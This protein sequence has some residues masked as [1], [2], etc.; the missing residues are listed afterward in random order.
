M[1]PPFRRTTTHS[2]LCGVY[3][4]ALSQVEIENS[5]NGAGNGSST[6]SGSVVRAESPV[7]VTPS[8]GTPSAIVLT[9][10]TGLPLATGVTGT[11]PVANGGTGDTG[12]AW[13]AFTPTITS[14]GGTVT[15]ETIA[16]DCRYKTIGKL[17]FVSYSITLTDI[18]TGSPTGGVFAT[19]PNGHT[20]KSQTI[21][22]KIVELNNS[23]T[24][25]AFT[26]AAGST[27]RLFKDDGSTYWLNGNVLAGTL[28]LEIE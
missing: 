8:L 6:G 19:L 28:M 21:V 25:Y 9:N 10:A 15:D 26:L 4:P 16:L 17:L 24:G 5:L 27:V 13:G 23:V 18:G 2:P 14:G 11:L 12:T 22:G 1:A 3:G 20:A 7:L